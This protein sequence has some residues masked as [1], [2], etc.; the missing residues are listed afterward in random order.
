MCVCV[1]GGGGGGGHNASHSYKRPADTL[2]VKI[3]IFKNYPML[4]KYN[5]LFI[6][7]PT[8]LA[9][10]NIKS[11]Q[12]L[13]RTILVLFM[14]GLCAGCVLVSGGRLHTEIIDA[15]AHQ[16]TRIVRLLATTFL[17]RYSFITGNALSKDTWRKLVNRICSLNI[18]VCIHTHRL[19]QT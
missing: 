16:V 6:F 17:P 2:F 13:L 15:H 10:V 5:I 18:R 8:N 7:R 19:I 3:I 14:V 11:R 12:T 9:D 4:N 1:L